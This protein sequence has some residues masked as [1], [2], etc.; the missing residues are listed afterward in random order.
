MAATPQ[1]AD[2]LYQTYLARLAAQEREIDGLTAR[3][4]ALMAAPDRAC[5]LWRSSVA[6]T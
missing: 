6:R 4:R 5:P 3:E 1:A 2:E